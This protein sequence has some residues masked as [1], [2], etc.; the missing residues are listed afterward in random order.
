MKIK[1]WFL[2]TEINKTSCF[3]TWDNHFLARNQP[4]KVNIKSGCTA[5]DV[6]NVN[7]HAYTQRERLLAETFHAQNVS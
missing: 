7:I 4:I 6:E 3:K 5:L 2:S 1:R